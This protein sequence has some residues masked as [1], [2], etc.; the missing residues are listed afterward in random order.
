MKIIIIITLMLSSLA[1]WAQT[2]DKNQTRRIVVHVRF[3][4]I[5]EG[6]T[7]WFGCIV[8][9]PKTTKDIDH[10]IC[11][12]VAIITSE[13]SRECSWSDQESENQPTITIDSACSFRINFPIE[14]SVEKFEIHYSSFTSPTVIIAN[15][16]TAVDTIHL[17]TIFT[18]EHGIVERDGVCVYKRLFGLIKQIKGYGSTTTYDYI[19]K[20]RA[21]DR[22]T[23][24]ET[25]SDRKL[26][27]TIIGTLNHDDV[28]SRLSDIKYLLLDY[29][30]MLPFESLTHTN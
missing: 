19:D 12:Q 2:G 15:I 20:Y 13:S 23:V 7:H 30:K 17:G 16:P 29:E 21:G 4:R 1:G 25:T 28:S 3:M 14:P 6:T 5:A 27:Y 26:S 8:K 9:E 24:H 10:D 18:I 11:G 22:I